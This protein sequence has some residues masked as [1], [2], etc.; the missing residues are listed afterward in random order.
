MQMNPLGRMPEG[1]EHWAHILTEEDVAEARYLRRTEG[2]PYSWLAFDY[3]VTSTAIRQA[4][5]GH[6]WQCCTEPVAPL[7]RKGVAPIYDKDNKLPLR[8]RII[9]AGGSE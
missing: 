1:E 3:G 8:F 7:G 5:I 4:C 6:T 2:W 9:R